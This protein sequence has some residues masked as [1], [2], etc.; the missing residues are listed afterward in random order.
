MRH[1]S[2]SASRTSAGRLSSRAVRSRLWEALEAT[3]LFLLFDDAASI[4][5]LAQSNKLR[6]SQMID[7]R[8]IL[9]LFMGIGIQT[10]DHR[11]AES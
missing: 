10:G 3:D 2:S 8:F 4:L 9:H 6:M 5:V 11:V 1:W 7:L